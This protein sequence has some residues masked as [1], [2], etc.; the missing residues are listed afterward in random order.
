MAALYPKPFAGE[1]TCENLHLLG[2]LRHQQ[3]DRHK[4]KLPGATAEQKMCLGFSC[5]I[6]VFR[7]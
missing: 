3:A 4:A 5:R 2:V 1:R 6:L 7:V